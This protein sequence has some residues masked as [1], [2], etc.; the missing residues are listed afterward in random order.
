M[1]LVLFAILSVEGDLLEDP[2]PTVYFTIN[3][4]LFNLVSSAHLRSVSME[5]GRTRNEAKLAVRDVILVL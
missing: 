5:A 1:H 2:E 4:Y 3:Y